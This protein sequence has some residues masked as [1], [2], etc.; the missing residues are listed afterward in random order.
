MGEKLQTEKQI[1]ASG[2]KLTAHFFQGKSR[3]KK[4][5][6][7]IIKGTQEEI[8]ARLEAMRSG[9]AP[10]PDG[11]FFSQEDD[12]LFVSDTEKPSAREDF[13]DFF[14][15]PKQLLDLKLRAVREG[16][17]LLPS[18][19]GI[20]RNE[21]LAAIQG[22]LNSIDLNFLESSLLHAI[23]EAFS[24]TDYPEKIELNRAGLYELMGIEKSL[25]AGGREYFREGGLFWRT[26]NKYHAA[27]I[28][29]SRK[30]Y[31]FVFRWKTG[32]NKKGEPTYTLVIT[33]EPI[34]KVKAF[35][36]DAE[37]LEIPGIMKGD[38]SSENRFSHYEIKLNPAAIGEVDHYFRYLPASLAREISDFRKGRRQRASV[39]E[40]N[41]IEFLYAVG[42]E[43]IEINY[44][45][46]AEKLKIKKLHDKKAV[47]KIL[48]RCYE[49]AQALGF[50]LRIEENTPAT[51]E[52]TKEVIYLNPERFRYLAQKKLF[53]EK[54]S[55]TEA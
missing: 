3:N 39:H 53:P 42:H 45:K 15:A 14:A 36:G 33:Y 43:L 25:S 23:V 29:L 1:K 10:L 30:S 9:K 22:G 24:R 12:I 13:L 26:R 52:G 51:K 50:V 34:V 6:T 5:K 46:L 48:R 32:Q 18:P 31:P 11:S 2:I 47:R 17:L 35:Y 4:L 28:G 54:E 8:R 55:N 20:N 16:D 40:F 49:M 38:R 19:P 41:F 7:F 44:M 27:L 37:G 21:M